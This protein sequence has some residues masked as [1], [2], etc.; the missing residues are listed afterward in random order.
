MRLRKLTNKR[1]KGVRLGCQLVEVNKMKNEDGKALSSRQA[2]AE[3]QGLNGQ[4]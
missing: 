4:D 2:L 3:T 1:M